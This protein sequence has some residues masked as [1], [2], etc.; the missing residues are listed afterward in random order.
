MM[1]FRPKWEFDYSVRLNE[2]VVT[3]LPGQVVN[4]PVVVTLDRGETHPVLLTVSTNWGSAGLIA[5]IIPPML[6]PNPAGSAT[7]VIGVSET[8]L[9]GSYFFTIRGETEGTFST[10]QDAVTVNVLPKSKENEKKQENQNS[11]QQPQGQP[12]P[13]PGVNAAASASN[14]PPPEQPQLPPAE[15]IPAAA[16]AG[17]GVA[18]GILNAIV[19]FGTL[20]I[21]G[22]VLYSSGIFDE[23]GTDSQGTT[24]DGGVYQNQYSPAYEQLKGLNNGSLHW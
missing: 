4:V 18:T 17:G 11:Q 7:M 15:A 10:S 23:L 1:V 16:S 8:T 22:A 9:P 12:E 2:H 19:F 20:A 14:P 6:S 21:V 5:Q 3:A 24:N 13:G